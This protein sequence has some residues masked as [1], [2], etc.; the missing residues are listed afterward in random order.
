MADNGL[1]FLEFLEQEGDVEKELDEALH[2]KYVI[3]KG[4]KKKKWKSDKPGFKIQYDKNG[5]P[6]EKRITGAERRH[7]KL[8]QRTGKIKRA[9][10]QGKI[11]LRQQLS[12]RLGSK[13]GIRK[14][15]VKST[16]SSLGKVDHSKDF[17]SKKYPILDN[18][19]MFTDLEDK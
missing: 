11:Q 10:I 15:D 14:P 12:N 5:I 13:I 3:R 19:F 2:V 9:A 8:G 17:L 18:N 16:G 4:K 6:H 1:G 7:R